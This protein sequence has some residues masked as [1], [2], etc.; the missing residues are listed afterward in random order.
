MRSYERI[1]AA[2]ASTPWA[3]EP[4]RGQEY[5]AILTRRVNGASLSSPFTG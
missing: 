4:A 5:A 1:L 2:V 3:L